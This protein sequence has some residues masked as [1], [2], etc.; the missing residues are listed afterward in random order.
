DGRKRC[1]AESAHAL[2]IRPVQWK[3]GEELRCHAAAA[4]GVEG[5]AGGAGSAALRTP[6][7]GEQ[8]GV[9]PDLAEP[10]RRPH[11]AGQELLVDRERAG[12]Y[13]A[14]RVDQAHDPARAAQVQAGEVL[15]VAGEVEEG[16]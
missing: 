13:V 16:V 7:V 9:S 4:A 12:V 6:E 10:A 5:R 2:R 11:V 14:H 8:R 1:R 15:A 3:S